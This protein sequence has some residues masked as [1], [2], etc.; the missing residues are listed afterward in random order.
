MNNSDSPQPNPALFQM[1]SRWVV[2]TLRIYIGL[3]LLMVPDLLPP[4]IGVP[5]TLGVGAFAA[6]WFV[7]W[8]VR[9]QKNVGTLVPSETV[10][11]WPV[12]FVY[13]WFL[14]IL[15]LFAPFE[16]VR[17][18]WRAGDMKAE[19]WG[20]CHALPV[21]PEFYLWWFCW[22][23]PGFLFFFGGMLYQVGINGWYIYLGANIISATLCA[24][25]VSAI[26]ARH[27][28]KLHAMEADARAKVGLALVPPR[29]ADDTTGVTVNVSEKSQSVEQSAP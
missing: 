26:T 23:V 21:P 16:H 5:L 1:Q 12:A 7:A 3:S 18:F 13:S 15:N 4:I 2:W 9:A 10:D 8:G 20:N 22:L 27:V 19:R 25:I 29:T 24:H 28:H 14:P 11:I 17:D 6:A